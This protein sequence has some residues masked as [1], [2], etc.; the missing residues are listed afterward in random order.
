MRA[1]QLKRCINAHRDT[2][3]NICQGSSPAL[4]LAWIPHP[5]SRSQWPPS[6]ASSPLAAS[7]APRRR[8]A[9]LVLHADC[10]LPDALAS[11]FRL[12]RFL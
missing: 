12:L 4:W 6:E 2:Q 11:E 9:R 8:E 7:L 5:T 10:F 1:G 3:A